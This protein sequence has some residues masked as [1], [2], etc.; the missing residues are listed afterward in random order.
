[1]QPIGQIQQNVNE[2][3]ANPYDRSALQPEQ[4]RLNLAEKQSGIF[5]AQ[6]MQDQLMDSR[7]LPW[8]R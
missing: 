1:M 4:M 2:T 5:S 7:K 8:D 3:Y 6:T